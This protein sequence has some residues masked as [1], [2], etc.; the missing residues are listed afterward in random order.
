[1][2]SGKIHPATEALAYNMR[3]LR[4]KRAVSQIALAAEAGTTTA[5]ISAIENSEGNPTLEVLQRLADALGVDV[6]VLFAKPD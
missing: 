3:V 5:T 4:A 2:A 1:M 6:G